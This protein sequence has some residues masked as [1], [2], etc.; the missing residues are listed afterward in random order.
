M[1]EFVDF[2][3]RHSPYDRLG[4][5]ELSQLGRHIN[6]AYYPANTTII[7]STTGTLDYL[8]IVRTGVVQVLDRSAVVD[9]L[10]P[11]D[12]FGQYSV[13]SRQAPSMTARAAS[14][15]LIYWLPDPRTVLDHPE[16]LA[17]DKAERSFGR[18]TLMTSNAVDSTLRPVTDFMAPPLWCESH[19]TIRDAA[20][21][22]TDEWRSCVLVQLGHDIGIMTDSDCRKRVA[23]GEISVQAP[24]STIVSAP[25]I[26]IRPD[27]TAAEAFIAMVHHG[28]HHLVVVDRGGRVV[29]V[30][31]V[32][33]L[34]A[35][36]IRDPLTIRSAIDSSQDMTQLADAA[37]QLR[38]TAVALYDAGVPPL[39]VGALLSA[40][41]DAI[42]EKIVRW[43]EPFDVS[44]NDFAWLVL[45]SH[46]RREPLPT[47][48]IDTAIIW[49]GSSAS[50]RGEQLRA[51]AERVIAGLE[52]C[53]LERCPD[54][55][56]AT[57]PLFSRSYD[58]WLQRAG[59]WR[60]H[61]D[62]N[63]AVLLGAM[64]ADSRPV[65]GLLL[66]RRLTES[67][68]ALPGD[69]AFVRR[70]LAESLVHRPPI[71]FVK[72]FIVDHDGAH[73]GQLDLKRGGLRPIVAIG[74]WIALHTK[75][76]IASTQD[77]LQLG[78]NEGLLSE[79]EAAQLRY[80]HR[81]I[82]EMLFTTQ[83]DALRDGVA[84]TTW[85]DPRDID[86]LRR[87]HL[88]QSFKAIHQVQTRLDTEWL[89]HTR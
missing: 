60:E 13:M 51:A 27:A 76:A 20:R 77:R 48:D 17:F 42:L 53:G 30:C 72:D 88:R 18:R 87:R 43:T 52:L 1:Q 39:R 3:G 54:G 63:G 79:D 67:V 7:D 69:E 29:G 75:S 61:S 5:D 11:G 68:Q 15:T 32:I 58:E 71:G 65:T 38:P 31:R 2:L 4:S 49:A 34:A 46:A 44:E 78:A 8:G 80:A 73:R 26:T 35:A 19:Q 59:Q 50:D 28:V 14:D 9:E 47:S 82:Y 33:D 70:V 25:A 55:A 21:M 86:S 41:V 10:G 23:T 85:L 37:T 57:N 74:R 40:M 24:I 89:G 16:K 6:V 45:G 84:A 36:E 22:M 62:A 56:N 12:T 64:L 81:E 66:G 83:I